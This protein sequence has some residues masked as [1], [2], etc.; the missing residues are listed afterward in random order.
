MRQPR[1]KGSV[2]LDR[3][4][5]TVTPEEGP[6]QD[7][8]LWLLGG[9]LLFFAVPFIGADVLG[10]QPDL[11][12]LGYFTVAL[13]WFVAFESTFRPR[14]HAL[15]RLNL[16]WSLVVGALAGAAVAAVV[17]RSSGTDHPDGWRW[18]FEIGWRGVVYGAVDAL[19]LFVFPAAVAYLLMHGDRRGAMRKVG[20]GALVLACSLLISASYH[21]GYPEYRDSTLR[22]PMIGTVMADSAAVLTGNP[23]GALLTHGVAHVSAVVHQEQGG[24]THM[25]PPRVTADY[26]DLGSRDLAAVLAGL[27]LLGVAGGLGVMYRR[28]RP[29][30]APD[31]DV[32]PG[33]RQQPGSRG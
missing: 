11:Y 24:A 23:V 13:G 9:A 21:L 4:D 25:L 12:Y 27:W 15:W 5:H 1:S 26:P 28:R 6:W 8:W 17:F 32:R 3:P 31:R 16:A 22:S 2:D 20:Y 33:Y 14:L 10:L 18:W 29:G 30:A 19:T 7:P